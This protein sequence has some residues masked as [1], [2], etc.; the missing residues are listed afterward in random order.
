MAR[1]IVL[2]CDAHLVDDERV[3]AQ[4]VT[5]SIDGA[6]TEIDLCDVD[7]KRYVE[8]LVELL[9]EY[10][11]PPETVVAAPSRRAPQRHG[12]KPISG[13][14]YECLWCGLDYAA[15]SGL[16]QHVI[17]KHGFA[18]LSVAYGNRCPLCAIA[19]PSLGR[20]ANKDHR[21]LA[22]R[23]RFEHYSQLFVAA[24]RK[25]GDPH[26]IVDERVAAGQEV[27]P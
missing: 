16:A 14:A 20:H 21:N 10:G 8:P 26:G 19:F 5:V 2:W 27:K 7:R 3:P 24:A 1:E 4:T 22:P 17:K 9:R 15:E 18:S 11:A 25:A 12:I 6:T 23:G 13:R